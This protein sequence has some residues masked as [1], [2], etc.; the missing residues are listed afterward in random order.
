MD[1]NKVIDPIHV[2]GNFLW[3]KKISPI[4]SPAL[5]GELFSTK[6][7]KGSWTWLNLYPAKISRIQ[8]IIYVCTCTKS[9]DHILFF[10]PR[11]FPLCS[12]TPLLALAF[13]LSP[14]S[15]FTATLPQPCCKCAPVLVDTLT[16][17]TGEWVEEGGVPVGGVS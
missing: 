6:I 2:R 10:L 15:L 17:C 16:P 14:P 3:E 4:S 11:Y 13:T 9:F 1:W 12:L 8:Y 5:I 7:Q